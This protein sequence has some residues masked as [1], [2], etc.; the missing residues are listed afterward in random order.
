LKIL[1]DRKLPAA[2]KD[3]LTMSDKFFNFLKI[4]RQ[5]TNENPKVFDLQEKDILILNEQG[6]LLK[7]VS[8]KE[9]N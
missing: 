9:I 7:K 6:K 1:E 4:I 5:E 8:P 3:L 2:N